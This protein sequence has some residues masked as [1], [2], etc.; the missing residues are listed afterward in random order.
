MPFFL[1]IGSFFFVGGAAGQRIWRR[2]RDAARIRTSARSVKKTKKTRAKCA[3][4]FT[5]IVLVELHPY[6]ALRLLGRSLD[7]FSA[8][9]SARPGSLRPGTFFGGALHFFP[10]L[11]LP[12]KCVLVVCMPL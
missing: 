11:A 7:F 6:W 5:A 1:G 2:R 10:T 9:W 4:V 12:K 3:L 8:A